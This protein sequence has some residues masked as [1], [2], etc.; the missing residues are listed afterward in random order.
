MFFSIFSIVKKKKKNH[1]TGRCLVEW[2][3]KITKNEEN[4][5]DI[6]SQNKKICKTK[7]LIDPSVDTDYKTNK[8]EAST[9]GVGRIFFIPF[10]IKMN[11]TDLPASFDYRSNEDAW[12]KGRKAIIDYQLEF[13]ANREKKNPVI[14]NHTYHKI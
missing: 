6:C 7:L 13:I 10:V 5:V 9:E 8:F 2:I 4:M 12:K 14:I 1:L 11:K 3:G